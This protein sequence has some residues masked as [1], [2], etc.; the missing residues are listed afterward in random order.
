[1]GANALRRWL[2]V[3]ALAVTCAC[4]LFASGPAWASDLYL[5][6]GNAGPNQVFPFAIAADGSLSPISCTGS[7]CTTGQAP[8]G[9][10]ISPD[11]HFLYTANPGSDTV[12]VFSVASDRSLTPIP[13]PGSD[14]AA[15]STPFS[16]AATPDGRFLYAV[17]QTLPG[18]VA[19]FSIGPDGTLTPIPCPGT[20]CSTPGLPIEAAVSTNGRFLY[21]TDAN[22][23]A[24]SVFAI[25]ADGSLTPVPCPGSDCTTGQDPRGIVVS[26]NGR[27][28]YTVN[29]GDST[30][31]PFAIGADG[32]L[33]PIACATCNAPLNAQA[34]AITP[35]GRFVYTATE[36]FPSTVTVSAIDAD[37]ALSPVACPGSNCVGGDDPSALLVS[38]DSR[39]LYV[40]SEFGNDHGMVSPFGIGTDGSLSPVICSACDTFTQPFNES[41][42]ITPDQAPTAAFTATSAP[43]DSATTFDAS[44]STASL[45]QTV[46]RYDWEFGD[47]TSATDAGPTP[48]HTYAAVGIYTVTLTV[49]DNA[50]CSTSL[51]FTGQTVSCNGGPGAQETMRV[52]I[53]A[54]PSAKIT[55]PVAGTTYAQ[56]QVVDSSFS[57]SEGTDGP[58]LSSCHD[59]AGHGSGA[60]LDTSTTGS[61]TFTVTATSTDGQ[62]ATASVTYAVASAPTADISKPRNEARYRFGQVVHARYMCLDGSSGPGVSSC[63]GTV[64]DGHPIG[65]SKAG[66]HNFTVTARSKDGQSTTRTISYAVLPDNH[67]A[68]SHIKVHANGTIT[69]RVRLPGAGTIN[70]LGTAWRNNVAE[71]TGLLQP[72]QGRFVYG[73]AHHVTRRR[74][75][76]PL[77]LMPN[78]HGNKLLLHHAYVVTLRLWV[79]YTPTNG[80]QRDAGFYGLHLPHD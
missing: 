42:A 56:G 17:D 15:G 7:N 50:G 37:G 75:T 41:L 70:V 61:H 13:C 8:G 25:G 10:V 74:G 4:G 53:A 54:P 9:I 79:S 26:P 12:S 1:V 14:C 21:T 66:R 18:A 78:A 39:F 6:S 16:L 69:L 67:F 71:T 49:T 77:R 2:T 20:N 76:V 32:L 33:T 22:T 27:F 51:V 80:Q 44:A 38:P 55:T 48:R 31:S 60:T 24:V 47:G 40:A 64:A 52:R 62:T 28:L 29:D 63:T 5:T 35:N 23:N 46:A 65:T 19:P 59:Q 43:P 58:G 11:D 36:T 3:A 73:R 57:C 72:A 34:L 30:V 68:V 45:G